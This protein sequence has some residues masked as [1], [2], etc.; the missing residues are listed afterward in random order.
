L[1]SLSEQPTLQPLSELGRGYVFNRTRQAFLAND[2][3]RANTHFSRLRGLMFT[4]PEHFSFGQALW[5][6]PSHGVHTFFMRYPIDVLYL[7][8]ENRIQHMEENIKPWRVAPV[9][10]ETVTVL[11]L[12]AHNAF[13]TGTQI[14]DQLEIVWNATTRTS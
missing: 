2:L 11:E 14:G 9:R 1:S 10:L 12:P 5:I 3:K 4:S 13:N 7:D 8:A 6:V